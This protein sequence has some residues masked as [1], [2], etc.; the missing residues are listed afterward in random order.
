MAYSSIQ[1]R[2]KGVMMLITALASATVVFIPPHSLH[3]GEVM[4]IDMLLVS[5]IYDIIKLT[6]REDCGSHSNKDSS[7]EQ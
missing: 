7:I 2:F 4:V 6:G 3:F 1:R 5:E